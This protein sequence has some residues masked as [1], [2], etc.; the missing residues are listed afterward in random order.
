[1]QRRS[2]RGKRLKQP[3]LR[4]VG[5][6]TTPTIRGQEELSRVPLRQPP[7]FVDLLFD[8][9]ALQ[10]V[11]LGLV[12]LEGAVHVVLPPTPRPILVLDSRRGTE[13]LRSP[14]DHK[15]EGISGYLPPAAAGK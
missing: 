1:M 3:N 7:D 8:L 14:P 12:A 2:K 15:A 10:V 5:S 9:Q 13:P 11:E 4:R 6:N